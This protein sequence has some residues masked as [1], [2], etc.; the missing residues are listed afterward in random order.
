[1]ASPMYRFGEFRL[2]PRRRALWRRDEEVALPAKPFACLVYLLEHRDRAVGRDELID[3]VWGKENLAD[4]VLGHAVFVVRRALDDSGEEPRYI[5]TV[6]GFGYRWAA[7]V[8]VV[9]AAEEAPGPFSRRSLRLSALAAILLIAALA[10]GAVYMSRGARSGGT[11]PAHAAIA[12]GEIALLLPVTVTAAAEHPWIRLGVMDLIASRLRAAGQPMVPSDTVIALLRDHTTEPDAEEIAGVAATTGA[13]LVLGATATV[14][15]GRWRVSLRSLRGSRPPLTA[16]A[17]AEEVLEAARRAADRMALSLGLKPPPPPDTD[18]GVETL[19][20]QAEAALLA[21]Q[22]EVASDLVE[23]ADVS[24]RRDPRVRMLSIRLALH[25]R[26]LDTA[27]AGFEALLRDPQ[28]RRDALLRSRILHGLAAVHFRR[29]DYAAAQPVLERAARLLAES[30]RGEALAT[31]GRVYVP[32]GTVVALN[33][34]AEAARELFARARLAFESTGDVLGLARLDNNLGVLAMQGERLDEALHY[35]ERSA[36]VRAAAHDVGGELRVR[37][38]MVELHLKRLEPRAA[39]ALESR[40]GELLAQTTNPEIGAQGRLARAALLRATGRSESADAVLDE[41]L[42]TLEGRADLPEVWAWARVEHA[43]RL[44]RQ[45]HA[46]DAARVTADVFSRLPPDHSAV[47]DDYVG[48]AWLIRLR[49]L[50]RTGDLE[51]AAEIPEAM[52]RWATA[53]S[54]SGRR[55]YTA[56]AEAE[57]AAAGGRI[58]AA[59]DAFERSLALADDGQMPLATLRVAESYASWLLAG[60][61]P[62]MPGPERALAVVERLSLYA[63][64]DYRAALLRL[65][66]YHAVG[67]AAAW[68]GALNRAR[69]LAGEQRQIPPELREPP[70]PG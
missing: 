18:P 15:A 55:L 11:A 61:G 13:R 49:A 21:Q 8:E 29:G 62:R 45:G 23:S 25:R 32:L 41:V 44:L 37:A 26:D 51:A 38:N 20:H 22:T 9:E 3:A 16:T 19:V 57:L 24:M 46:A 66:V 35:F 52:R 68:R 27:Q 39:L 59:G 43:D 63:D 14:S 69:S 36:E 5:Q 10:V 28:V 50:L 33:Q 47:P 6:R 65:R 67:H 34:G 56:L 58:A 17:E 1:M 30:R 4:S 12:E 31:L 7:P 42:E 54:A 70:R 64:R 2:D 53:A 48:R 40:L 60:V